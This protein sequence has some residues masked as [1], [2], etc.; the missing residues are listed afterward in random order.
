MKKPPKYPSKKHWERLKQSDS[1]SLE[2]GEFCQRWHV[3]H[4]D[5]ARICFV[6]KATV[7]NWFR[8][9]AKRRDA[10][11]EHKRRLFWA[12]REWNAVSLEDLHL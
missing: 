4:A 7:D 2:P 12:D 9:G 6:S 8:Q 5:L 10:R 1:R 11:P 3:T